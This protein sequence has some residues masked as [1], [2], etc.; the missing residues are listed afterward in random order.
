MKSVAYLGLGTN[1]GTN[2]LMNM[3][4]IFH[5]LQHDAKVRIVDSSHVYQSK[6]TVF[7]RLAPEHGDYLNAV[8]KIETNMSP[9]AL[10]HYVKELEVKCFHRDLLA[11][12]HAS[13]TMD[14]DILLYNN[15]NFVDPQLTIPHPRMWERDF[16][17]RPLSDIYCATTT[18]QEQM[19]TI[20][21]TVASYGTNLTWVRGETCKILGIMN[22]TPDSFS[23]G[24]LLGNTSAG[25]RAKHIMAK[26]HADCFD[27]GG[28]STRPNAP[29]VDEQEEIARVV[30]VIQAAMQ[31]CQAI[32][33]DTT[34]VTVARAAL[35]AG[36]TVVNDVSCGGNRELINLVASKPGTNLVLMHSK[37]NPQT[38]DALAKHESTGIIPAVA[39]DLRERVN[40][41]VRECGLPRWRIIIDPGIGFA[42]THKQSLELLR[43]ANELRILVDANMP[44]MIAHSRKRFLKPAFLGMEDSTADWPSI[45]VRE[46]VNAQATQQ[47][48]DNGADLIRV[49]TL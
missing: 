17:T 26:L 4:S 32:S 14:I 15:T 22:A 5:K 9:L 45:E 18:Q 41:A 11:A 1:V 10:L 49:H 3:D 13:R 48:I 35:E 21:G 31:H 6:A 2:L 30:P 8:L 25:E 39:H 37:G 43:G 16:V 46:R 40:F 42:K 34:K 28:E 36:C 38:M 27:I 20:R 33:I 12:R 44:V 7:N 29:K 24:G 47:A 23:D 19:Q